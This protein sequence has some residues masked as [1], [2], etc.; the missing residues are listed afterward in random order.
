VLA[1]LKAGNDRGVQRAFLEVR[2]SNR[3]AL[4]LY[5]GLGFIRS[6]VR[7]GYY[8]LPVENAVVMSLD[9]DGI[10]KTSSKPERNEQSSTGD[11]NLITI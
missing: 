2:E 8:D 9:H 4:M 1:A 11:S 6:L 3:A 7:E 5:E 10:V